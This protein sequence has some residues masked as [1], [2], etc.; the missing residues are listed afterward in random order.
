MLNTEFE[1]GTV[2]VKCAF[3]G[4]SLL[5]RTEWDAIQNAVNYGMREIVLSVQGGWDKD[6]KDT[7]TLN[8][9]RGCV[10]VGLEIRIPDE[11]CLESPSEGKRK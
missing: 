10:R 3:C 4:M 7:I 11:L 2:Y 9:C 8:I 1:Y 5:G 6:D